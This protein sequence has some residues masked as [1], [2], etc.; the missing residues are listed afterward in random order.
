VKISSLASLRL[1]GLGIVGMFLLASSV[2]AE[3]LYNFSSGYSASLADVDVPVLY[4]GPGS[5]SSLA[6]AANAAAKESSLT[7]TGSPVVLPAVASNTVELDVDPVSGD[8]KLNGNGAKIASIQITS[9]GHLVPL[10]WNSLGDQGVPN[11]TDATDRTT[12]GLAEYDFKFNTK[13]DSKLINGVIDYGNIFSPG[14]AHD[15][16]FQYGLVQPDGTTLS[17]ITGNVVYANTPEPT[18][19]SLLGLGAIGLLKRRNRRTKGN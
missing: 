8:V 13:H 7:L 16:V 15:L 6:P 9:N 2:R 18:S 5:L 12:T 10:S 11:W 14:A 3:P 1:R 17:T 19:L 4:S